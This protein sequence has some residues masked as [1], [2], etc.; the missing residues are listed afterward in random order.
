[1]KR[2]DE[3]GFT[4]VEVTVALLIFTV[5]IVGLAQLMAVSL[6]MQSLGRN[7]TSAVR[8]AQDKL[9]ELMSMHFDTAP[10]IQITGSDSLSADVENYFDIDADG[11]TRRWLVEDGPDGNAN[12][13]QITIRVIPL[14]QDRRTATPYDLVSIIR[15]W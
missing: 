8:L 15:R 7:Q 3:R 14:V 11:T 9:D 6:H 2:N 12:L 13:R 5:G 4:L 1:M 10:E